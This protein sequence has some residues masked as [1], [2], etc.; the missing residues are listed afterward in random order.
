M[1]RSIIVH[2]MNPEAESALLVEKDETLCEIRGGFCWKRMELCVRLAKC[3]TRKGF[4][5]SHGPWSW[6][7]GRR[8]RR[9]DKREAMKE[10]TSRNVGPSNSSL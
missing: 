6:K 7:E 9:N 1:S 4:S 2:L 8:R 3:K 10:M 5:L